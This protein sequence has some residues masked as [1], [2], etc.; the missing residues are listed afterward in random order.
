MV[1]LARPS[2]FNAKCKGENW[3][4]GGVRDAKELNA[5][6]ADILAKAKAT[7]KVLDKEGEVTTVALAKEMNT[8]VVSSSFIAFARERAQMIYDN[9]GW[10]NWRKYCGLINKLDAFRKKRRM[11]DITVADM[12]VELL[13]RF[14][15]FLHKW[16]NEREPGKLL[17]SN[18]IEVQFNILRTLVHRAIEVGIMEASKDPFLV[19]KYKGVKTIKE[20]LDD[21]EMERIINL[22]LEEGSLIWHCKNYF[23]FSYYCA[24]IRAADLIQLRWRNVTENGR[25]HY[26]MGK[27]HKDRDLLLVDQ[28]L[29]ILLYYHNDDV[30]PD[31]Y[32]FPLLDNDAPFAKFVTQAD[33]NRMKP[34]LR[35][36][37]YQQISAKNALI[38]KYLKKIAE[39]AEITTNL[40][41]HISRHAF[42]HIAQEAD[43]ESSAIKNILGHS[44]LATTERYMG[45]FDTAKTD[46]TL[47]TL[48]KKKFAPKVTPLEGTDS[49]MSKEKKAIEL[50]KGMTPEQIMAV[51]SAINK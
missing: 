8:E 25:L 5:Q 18:T 35:H 17:H 41:M 46:N 50:L 15:N 40:T 37:L 4:R 44:N 12:T 21:S 43:A 49:S 10:R 47:R 20:K 24:G 9:G 22:E 6:L 34:E 30:K 31:D 38:N 13:T 26:Q 1:E 23:L 11:A 7:Y 45:S 48:F 33:K 32:I 16:E 51:I 28:A 3:V 2:D 42:A 36:K 29:D 39:K 19:F 14:D 27:N